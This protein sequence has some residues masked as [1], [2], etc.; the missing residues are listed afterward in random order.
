MERQNKN[1]E[2]LRKE[3]DRIDKSLIELFQ[4]RMEQVIEIMEYKMENKLPIFQLD[5]EERVIQ[6]ALSNLK[7]NNFANEVEDYIK[8]ILKISRQMQSQKL[9]PY[10]ILLIGFMGTGKTTVGRD[11]AEKLAMDYID[12]D[13]LIQGRCNMS[14]NDI[15]KH[16]GENYFRTI[17]KDIIKEISNRKNTLILCG[18]GVVLH[19]ENIKNLRKNGK[20][21]LLRA[22]ASTIYQR[23]KDEDTRPLLKEEMSIQKIE[24]LLKNRDRAYYNSADIIIDTDDKSIGEISVE[25]INE[26]YNIKEC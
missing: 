19:D 14:I 8:S 5:R 12:T 15:F 22:K 2:K 20:S 25:I 17:E 9:F 3:I 13:E 7:D 16:Y 10:N 23:I 18:G 26:L 4:E 6:R 21:I 24:V 11:L 1:I